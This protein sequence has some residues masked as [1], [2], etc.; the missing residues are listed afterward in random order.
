MS[1][2][3]THRTF[4]KRVA[5][6]P[7]TDSVGTSP[8]FAVYSVGP[9]DLLAGDVVLLSGQLGVTRPMPG[10]AGPPEPWLW[11]R[12]TNPWEAGFAEDHNVGVITYEL[13]RATDPDDVTAGASET[14]S[15]WATDNILQYMHHKVVHPQGFDVV[16][17][18]LSQRYYNL[19][20]KGSHGKPNAP[21]GTALKVD[22]VGHLHAIVLRD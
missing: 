13:I 6:L 20:A 3:Y 5:T 12:Q 15:K 10:D 8:A 14:V 9:F 7:T 18:T 17:S 2:I 21:P 11:Y 16:T 1:I 19:V 4:T 22:D